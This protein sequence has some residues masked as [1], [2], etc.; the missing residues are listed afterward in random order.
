MCWSD[1]EKIWRSDCVVVAEELTPYVVDFGLMGFGLRM[2]SVDEDFW[3][4][5]DD[6]HIVC[7]EAATAPEVD[8]EGWALGICCEWARKAARKLF[9]KD[10]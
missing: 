7:V 2:L 3:D 8:I 1:C 10:L 4:D 6:V 5:V 9:K